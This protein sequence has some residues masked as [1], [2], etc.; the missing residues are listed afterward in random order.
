MLDNIAQIKKQAIKNPP[1]RGVYT[2]F[3]RNVRG[4]SDAEVERLCN[5]NYESE[6][7]FVATTGGREAEEIVGQSCYFINP[8]SNLA[9]TAYMVHPEWQG[10]GLGSALQRCMMARA[11]RV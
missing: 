2:R 8:T 3:F 9:D 10:S 11:A 6:V 7:A 5:V 1:K 4:L